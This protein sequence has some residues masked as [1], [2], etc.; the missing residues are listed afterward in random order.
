M[1]IKENKKKVLKII[2]S[3]GKI[4]VYTEQS[5][6]VFEDSAGCLLVE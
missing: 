4:N 1:E 3:W 6:A 2:K 5:I